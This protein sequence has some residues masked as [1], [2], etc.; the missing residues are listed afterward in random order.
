MFAEQRIKQFFQSAAAA[1]DARFDRAD[2]AFEHFRN[3]LVAQTFQVAQDDGAAENI[4]HLSERLLHHSLNFA[5]SQLI[6]RRGM[7]VF[8]L[9]SG[10]TLLRLSVDRNVF[11]Q[12]TLEPAAMVEGL[13]NGD[14]VKP[15]LQ[16]TAMAKLA[17]ALESLQ[18]N[19]LR[20]V[21]RVRRIAQHAQYEVEDCGMVVSDQPIEC[22]F[23]AG[24]KL[25]DQ[26]RFVTA[27]GE[28]AGPIG[29][30]LAFLAPLGSYP[31]DA[32]WPCRALLAA[33][34]RVLVRST[35]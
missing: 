35:T 32:L 21:G 16:R 24:L 4:R 25:G 31:Y 23:R 34:G 2:A 6:E 8:D 5:R 10:L 29:H 1:Q 20:A 22:G 14:A 15:S 13:A 17:N 28:G 30:A 12:M 18:K 33:M 7:Q 26:L 27:P 9:D 11:L 3:F 19:F